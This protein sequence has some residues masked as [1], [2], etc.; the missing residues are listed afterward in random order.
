MEKIK[1]KVNINGIIPAQ[2]YLSQEKLRKTKESFLEYPSYGAIYIILYKNKYF[3]I[4]GHHRL[5]HLQQEGIKE[6][7]V[8]NEISDNTHKLYQILAEESLTLELKNI[9]S[10]KNR[11]LISHKEYE[12]KWIQKCQTILKELKEKDHF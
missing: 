10:L 2:H 4:D 7:E 11:I 9:S 1:Y 12:Q 3:S 5:Y 6:I 8:I